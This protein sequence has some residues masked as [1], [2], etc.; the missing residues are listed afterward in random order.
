MNDFLKAK[1]LL[2]DEIN[3]VMIKDNEVLKSKEKG[4]AFLFS[5][6]DKNRYQGYSVADKIVG[7]AAA[8]LYSRM[9]V[10]NVYG[11]TMSKKAIEV[12]KKYNIHVEYQIPVENIYNRTY[13]GLCPMEL[14]VLNIEEK[15]E[16]FKALKDKISQ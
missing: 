15:E 2:V 13:T 9:Q 1:E 5:L 7:K 4:I 11:K 10:K 16:A 12:L 8:F 14:T 6:A 3:L